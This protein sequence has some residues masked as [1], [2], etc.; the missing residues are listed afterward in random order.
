MTSGDRD[1]HREALPVVPV[2]EGRQTIPAS[3]GGRECQGP[4]A[5]AGS[6]HRAN[7]EVLPDPERAPREFHEER[8]G[9]VHVS[10]APA[11]ESEQR[12]CR[13]Q[14]FDR[15][16]PL[17]HDVHVD[18]VICARRIQTGACTTGENAADAGP[19]ERVPDRHR[20]VGQG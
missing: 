5:T 16:R 4:R 20:N 18:G 17:E 6:P 15:R 11:P 8:H 10:V 12:E 9:R 3:V 1:R 13:I 14:G 7:L 2:I 19:P